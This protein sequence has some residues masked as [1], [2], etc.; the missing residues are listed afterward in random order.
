MEKK[1]RF[2]DLVRNSGRPEVVT[3]WTRPEGN[4]AV[5]R[6]IKQNRVLTIIQEPGKRPYG[7]FGL[8]TD[9]HALFLIFPRRLPTEGTARVIGINYELLEQ[10][11]VSGQV[12][13]AE[14]KSPPPKPAR[15]PTKKHF[16][17]RV[18]RTATLEDEIAVEA[19]D[20]DKAEQVA[21]QKAKRKRFDLSRASVR[22]EVVPH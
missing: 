4:P 9:H 12:R 18:L 15:K 22:D 14:L 7:Y 17:F 6:A 16:R 3:L 21:R 19:T 11:A 2:G 1:I 13:P 5:S 20:K 10:P 8:H